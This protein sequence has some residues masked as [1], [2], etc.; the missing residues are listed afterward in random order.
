MDY[1]ELDRLLVTRGKRV[2]RK[3]LGHNTYGV[4]VDEFTI[5]I[6][7]HQTQ[8]VTWRHLPRGEQSVTLDSGGWLTPPTKDR[9]CRFLPPQIGL[10]SDHGY[11]WMATTV[12]S[13]GAEAVMRYSEESG[14]MRNTMKF[15]D[16]I[17]FVRTMPSAG[18]MLDLN[19]IPLDA[20]K[21]DIHNAAVDIMIKRAMKAVGTKGLTTCVVC[22]HPGMLDIEQ[23]RNHVIEHILADEISIELLRS[24][25]T[26]VG[27]NPTYWLNLT[28]V[29]G[30][31]YVVTPNEYGSTAG[32]TMKRVLRRY[33]VDLLYVGA[34][35][36]ANGR[37]PIT[38]PA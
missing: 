28:V 9:M 8:I 13:R 6:V 19:S 33:L 4:R 37:R 10:W 17:T 25:F 7:L 16:G 11:W 14:A 1:F 27:Y 15:Y 21:M 31:D 32:P 29:T 2:P 5:G 3:K 20:E 23:W 34:R 35:V 38:V 26:R 30:R 18:Y 24:A 22:Q 36:G 12:D